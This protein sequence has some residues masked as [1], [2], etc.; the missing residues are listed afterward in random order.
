MVGI[1]WLLLPPITISALLAVVGLADAYELIETNY[2][3]ECTRISYNCAEF[4]SCCANRT[5][6]AS[7]SA[8]NCVEAYG[9]RLMMYECRGSIRRRPSVPASL[10]AA[11]ASSV[12]HSQTCIRQ[13]YGCWDFKQC[14][15]AKAGLAAHIYCSETHKDLID[16]FLCCESGPAGFL[17]DG[18]DYGRPSLLLFSTLLLLLLRS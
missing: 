1:S 8:F 5:R 7:K 17:M 14:C 10:A 15:R 6:Y 9:N 13:A 18:A 3:D 16:D 12:D 11:C 4:E 2:G